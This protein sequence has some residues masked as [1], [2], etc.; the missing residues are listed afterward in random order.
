MAEDKGQGCG[1]AWTY[2]LFKAHSFPFWPSGSWVAFLHTATHPDS[3]NIKQRAWSHSSILLSLMAM[4]CPVGN[5]GPQDVTSTLASVT[6]LY[7]LLPQKK[8]RSLT[9]IS[10]LSSCSNQ[11][12][13]KTRSDVPVSVDGLLNLIVNF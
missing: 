1:V 7:I 2:F 9:K 11:G 10:P 6:Q 8:K 3:S 12:Q 5:T 13:T 4:S